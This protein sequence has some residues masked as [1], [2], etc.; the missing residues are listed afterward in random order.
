MADP[1]IAETNQTIAADLPDRQTG[2]KTVPRCVGRRR[3]GSALPPSAHT[4]RGLILIDA[5]YR[6][7]DGHC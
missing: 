4:P 1:S 6:G 2:F 3:S 7:R 5:E